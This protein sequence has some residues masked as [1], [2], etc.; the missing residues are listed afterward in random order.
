MAAE[1][2]QKVLAAAGVASRRGEQIVCV[3][4]QRIPERAA[5]EEPAERDVGRRDAGGPLHADDDSRR[6]AHAA[7]VHETAERPGEQIDA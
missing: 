7:G 6:A 1:R 3:P 5:L 2:L 4:G